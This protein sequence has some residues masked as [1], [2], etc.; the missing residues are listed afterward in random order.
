MISSLGLIW[1]LGITAA[2]SA[3]AFGLLLWKFDPQAT[4]TLG[5]VLFL[6]SLGIFLISSLVFAIHPALRRKWSDVGQL[7]RSLRQAAEIAVGVIIALVLAYFNLLVWWS[8]ILT[9]VLLL[10][11]EVFFR[12]KVE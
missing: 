4:G 1:G 10:G 12:I 6:V 8:I 7:L 5:L 3:I 9:I 2:S 11:L